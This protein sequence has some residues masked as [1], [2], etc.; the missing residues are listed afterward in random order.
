MN[1]NYQKMMKNDKKL[2]KKWKKLETFTI[3][4]CFRRGQNLSIFYQCF[5]DFF[6][7]AFL[8]IIFYHF[9]LSFFPSSIFVYHFF[10]IFYHFFPAALL[11]IIFSFFPAAFLGFN[12]FI[13]SFFYSSIF[14]YHFFIICSSNLCW[15]H[16]LTI[17]W[18]SERITLCMYVCRYVLWCNAM[19]NWYIHICNNTCHMYDDVP[20]NSNNTFDLLTPLC[21]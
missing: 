10:I 12:F 3:F 5:I 18:I 20:T 19:Y 6:P 2:I 8:C 11:C 17:L 4:D 21:M 15:N 14:W 13:F 16:V 1:K 7:A 9:F